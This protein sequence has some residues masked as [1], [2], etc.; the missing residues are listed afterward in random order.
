LCDWCL[1][2]GE[3]K[4]WYLNVENQVHD[5]FEQFI[6]ERKKKEPPPIA[7]FE[8]MYFALTQIVLEWTKEKS[9]E[10]AKE[11]RK[12]AEERVHKYNL[13]QVV[14]LEEAERILEI[15]SPIAVYSCPC[16]RAFRARPTE[17]ICLGF[18][19][20]LDWIRE[21]PDFYRGGVNHLSQEEAK[22][23][24]GTL[25]QKGL[26]HA[27]YV[28]KK[29]YVGGICNCEYPTCIPLRISLERGWWLYKKAE[30]V[31]A[32]DQSRCDG[33]GKCVTKCQFGAIKFSPMANIAVIN[34]WKCFGCGLC[35]QVCE[36][37]AIL[38]APKE[39]IEALKNI[40][41]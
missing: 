11:L 3:G 38:L 32:L 22:E 34:P 21:W 5:F 26:V 13:H 25:D 37:K 24:L 31:A 4:K 1:E 15:A 19:L 28:Y 40:W 23:L 14:P 10:V 36:V 9:P 16:Q 29:P 41:W 7:Q 2:H 8:N 18:G 17:K 35:R 20:S 12:A 27:V 6:K 30:Y 33:C 39:K